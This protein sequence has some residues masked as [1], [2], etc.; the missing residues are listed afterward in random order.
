MADVTMTVTMTMMRG[1]PPMKEEARR[2]RT[3]LRWTPTRIH[4]LLPNR[5]ENGTGGLLNTVC[6][7]LGH[8]VRVKD[9][10]TT[11]DLHHEGSCVK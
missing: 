2:P 5:N 8:D 3:R 10:H 7:A 1:G 9:G 6:D 11:M 4:Y